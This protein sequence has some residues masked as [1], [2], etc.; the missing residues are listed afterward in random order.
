MAGGILKILEQSPPAYGYS[1][2]TWTLELLA[3][4]VAQ[5]LG[6]VL[7]VGNLGKLLHLSAPGVEVR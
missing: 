4:V 7:S 5:V 3:K 6:V 1:R 2:W